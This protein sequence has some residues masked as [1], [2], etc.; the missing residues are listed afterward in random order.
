M[1]NLALFGY[2]AYA[3]KLSQEDLKDTKM[4]ASEIMRAEML[5]KLGVDG[6]NFNFKTFR[7]NKVALFEIIEEVLDLAVGE[8]ITDQ[9]DG[10]V[11]TRNLALGDTQMFHI[12]SQEMFK[13][14]R[15]ADGTSD[16][17]RQKLDNGQMT[18]GTQPRGVKI[19]TELMHFLTGRIDWNRMVQKLYDSIMHDKK[20]R[21]Y[22][23]IIKSFDAVSAPYKKSGAFD[24]V[25]LVELG[26]LVE[27]KA[28]ADGVVVLGTKSALAKI[29]PSLITDGQKEEL[30]RNGY[31]G[32]VRGMEL[33]EIPQAVKIGTDEFA[34]ADDFLLVLPKGQE[35]F[36]KMVDKGQ[37]IVHEA[38]NVEGDHSI[39]FIVT[40]EDGI[41]VIQGYVWGVYNLG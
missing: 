3:G 39:D 35:Q 18:V 5:E 15:I 9:F 32:M 22:D 4:T 29:Q 26:A 30:A 7:R 14:A 10:L 37:V 28:I 34:I 40:F 11:E 25:K 33:R 8:G 23:T 16:L 24:E 36:V 21:I 1:E 19:Y 31:V 2:N 13:I 20:I 41:A 38:N 27:A 6:T 17:R 12:E